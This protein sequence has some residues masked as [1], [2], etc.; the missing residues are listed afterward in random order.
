MLSWVPLGLVVGLFLADIL[1]MSVHLVVLLFLIHY[2]LLL[3]LFVDFVCFI[4]V[5]MCPF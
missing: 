1:T 2:P 3:S 5:F 4:L